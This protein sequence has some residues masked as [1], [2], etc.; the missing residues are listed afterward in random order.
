MQDAPLGGVRGVCE[1]GEDFG[2]SQCQFC[3]SGQGGDACESTCTIHGT[4]SGHGLCLG[5]GGCACAAGWSGDN[6]STFGEPSVDPELNCS[7]QGVCGDS[8]RGVCEVGAADDSGGDS[9]WCACGDGFAGRAC[10]GTL[11]VCPDHA[12]SVSGSDNVTDCQCKAGFYG[13]DGRECSVCPAKSY[14]EG[15]KSVVSCGEHSESPGGSNISEACSCE[16]GWYGPQG[17]ACTLCICDGGYTAGSD[18]VECTACGV[19][20]Y[21]SETGTG[22]C[23]SCPAGTNSSAG[24][25][26]VHDCVCVAGYTAGSDG[27]ECTACGAGTFKA[28]TG[29]G[30]CS[31]CPSGTSSGAGSDS[32]GALACSTCAAGTGN[33]NRGS[34]TVDACVQCGV[35]TWSGDG[36]ATCADCPSYTSSVGGGNK[37]TGCTCLVGYTA[38]SDGVSCSACEAGTF[39]SARGTGEC[40]TCPAGTSS[41]SGSNELTDCKCV[42]GHS[43]T[44]DG[45]ACTACEEGTYKAVAGA[46]ECLMC[47]TSLCGVGDGGN[48]A[49]CSLNR[50]K[51][52]VGNEACGSCETGL[53]TATTGALSCT[54]VSGYV[55]AS[56]GGCEQCSKVPCATGEYRGPCTVSTQ[57]ACVACTNAIPSGAAYTGPG[58]PFNMNACLWA[59][60]EGRDQVGGACASTLLLE[61]VETP[62]PAP[63]GSPATAVVTFTVTLQMSAAQFDAVRPDYIVNPEP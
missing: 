37:K 9:S 56:T 2:G 11:S 52:S 32:M 57:S 45:V 12:A 25:D 38:A 36:A 13:E 59:C 53:G 29:T 6:C 21:K 1:C 39:K 24:S 17:G 49:P 43:G 63:S 26:G 58:E 47:T 19:G 44:L 5:G 15:G 42:V 50:Y 8:G 23:S 33:N 40:S 55:L 28:T 61:T 48:C 54:C 14:C 30:A 51:A 7:L 20:T 46:G 4:C 16:A 60:E 62:S 22:A 3:A 27:A 34:T 10:G 35:N 31:T 41:A 18:G